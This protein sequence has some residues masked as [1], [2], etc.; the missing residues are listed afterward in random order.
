VVPSASAASHQLKLWVGHH[1]RVAKWAACLAA[2][3][4][5]A[6][7]FTT[8]ALSA[9]HSLDIYLHYTYS[10]SCSIYL[11]WPEYLYLYWL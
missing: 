7:C 10:Y 2:H 5:G 8:L 4:G 9:K 11:H 1:G 6:R 3:F